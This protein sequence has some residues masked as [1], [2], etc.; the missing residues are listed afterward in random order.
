MK[1]FL[2]Q[3]SQFSRQLSTL[4]SNTPSQCS[5]L[6]VR[7]QLSHPHRTTGKISPVYFNL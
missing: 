3:F 7:D 1:L 6:N 2:M 4:F 5:S